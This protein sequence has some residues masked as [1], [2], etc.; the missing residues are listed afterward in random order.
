MAFEE[1]TGRM[2]RLARAA[3]RPSGVIVRCGRFTAISAYAHIE[4]SFHFL[5]TI[6]TYRI[7]GQNIGLALAAFVPVL[8]LLL[9][10][11]LLFDANGRRMAFAISTLLFL[12]YTIAQTSAHVRGLKIAC[13]CFGGS[14]DVPINAT[15]IGMATGAMI[16][17]AIGWWLSR[18]PRAVKS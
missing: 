16:A 15:S 2:G 12:T 3:V 4:N 6:F 1:S 5:H 17:S 18:Q 8:Q 14:D 9:A 7:V 10:I 11:V 13:G